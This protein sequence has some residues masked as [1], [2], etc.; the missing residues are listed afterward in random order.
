ML[1]AKQRTA[2]AHLDTLAQSIFVDMFGDPRVNSNQ[3]PL[4]S[5]GEL[6]TRGPQN[7]IYKPASDYGSGTPILRIDGFYD[8]VVTNLAALRRV[9]IT[10]QER[11]TYGLSPGEIVVN[12]VNSLPYLGKC[13]IVPELDE[14]IVFESNMMRLNID[15]G[16]AEPR[17]LTQFLQ[18]AF[19]RSQILAAAE[20]AVNQA[21]INQTDVKSLVVNVP[22]LSLQRAFGR[23][24]RGVSCFATKLLATLALLDALLASL[25]DRAFRRQL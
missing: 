22:P 8:G 25:Q 23:R 20:R 4:V 21:S 1:C 12:R 18:T 10:Q 13:A 15:A 16:C 3:W 17:Y 19:V 11:D 7:G 2:L 9:R 24:T 14:T 6:L 5:L